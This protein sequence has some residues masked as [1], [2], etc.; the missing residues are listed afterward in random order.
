MRFFGIN[1]EVAADVAICIPDVTM[2]FKK[3][4]PDLCRLRMAA[5]PALE[6][7]WHS[8]K[9]TCRTA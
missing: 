8:R 4:S 9:L 7:H 3:E 2:Q 5:F 6:F 1:I